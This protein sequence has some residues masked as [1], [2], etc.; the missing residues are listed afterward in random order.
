[1]KILYIFTVVL[2][3]SLLSLSTYSQQ[4]IENEIVVIK[5]EKYIL[6]NVRMGETIVSISKKYH[7]TNKEIISNN[8]KLVMGL[9]AGDILQIPYSD[10]VKIDEVRPE[11][12]KGAPTD[13]ITHKILRRETPYF[14]A[15]KYGITIEEINLYNPK[16][17][18]FR[19]GKTIN[20]PQWEIKEVISDKVTEEVT[21]AD[22]QEDIENRQKEGM[23]LHQVKPG[24]TL[25]SLSKK[26]NRSISEILFYNPLAQNPA[27]G[28]E[29]WLP[30]TSTF[31]AKIESPDVRQK[32]GIFLHRIETGETL[33]GLQKKYNISEAELMQLNPVLESGFPAGVLLEI[34]VTYIDAPIVKPVN[35]EAFVHHIVKSK[36]TLYRLSKLY[37]L[38]IS[39]LKKYN[40][41]LQLRDGLLEGETILIP[42]KPEVPENNE[43]EITE[44]VIAKVP[45]DFYEIKTVIE[46]PEECKPENHDGYFFET[47]HVGLI[48]PLFLEANDT[49][50]KLPEVD[51][52]LFSEDSINSYDIDESVLG[53]DSIEVED[54]FVVNVEQLKQFYGTTENFLAFYEGAL[55]AVDEM[56]KLGMNIRLHVFDSK[57]DNTV[58]DSLVY[59][60]EFLNLDL[61]IGPI[62][63]QL[64][65][66]VADFAFKNRIPMVSPLS[67]NGSFAENNPYYFQ[68]NPS[69]NY[70]MRKTADFIADEY[71]DSNFILLQVNSEKE[72]SYE[73]MLADL[74][75][76]KLYNSGFYGDANDVLFQE[77]DFEKYGGFGLSRILSKEK[78]NVFFIPTSDEGKVS[79]GV[80]NINNNASDFDI[81]VVGT[82]RYEQFESISME[83]F[84]NVK[85]KFLYPY[86]VDYS[87]KTA[88]DFYSKFRE[89]FKTEPNRFSMQG[90]DATFYFLNA[91]YYYG[92]GFYDC[93]PYLDVDLVQGNYN[94]ERVSQFGGFM[95]HGCSIVSYNKD[96]TV[97]RKQ[98]TGKLRV[99][100]GK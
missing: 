99:A 65:K 71:F 14:V 90:H 25:Y 24:E 16:L 33:Y 93:L 9:K 38:K 51:S 13:F 32:D 4:K 100:V 19:K 91:L 95:N 53:V 48:L 69:Q 15:K 39:E 82:N 50:N 26:Y 54:E 74:I 20:I 3:L 64:Q 31:E 60:G 87:N 43:A 1:M 2:T 63:P 92:R 70:L 78:E 73:N 35:D 79:V 76:E 23:F 45:D 6:H 44:E 59:S 7:V 40:P 37:D 66:T 77:Y 49:L 62:Y 8:P 80:S 81:T 55:I 97:T 18:R 89:T 30:N 98:T 11:M 28:M 17:K 27:I 58:V 12:K 10:E 41:A 86:W 96:Y 5:G 56:Q 42:Q 36:E 52:L 21:L 68:V 83:Y 67:S 72:N 75:R 94:F 34:P 88:I 61:I 47:Y 84:H 29:I 46:V 57:R 22:N 85:L